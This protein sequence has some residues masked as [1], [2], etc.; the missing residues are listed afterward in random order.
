MALEELD[1]ERYQSKI[2]QCAAFLVDNQAKNG[3]WSYGAPIDLKAYP[4]VEVPKKDESVAKG[5]RDFVVSVGE[6]KRLAKQTV[7]QQRKA[8]GEKGANSI[9][10]YASLGLRHCHDANIKLPMECL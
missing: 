9:P 3:Q 8:S 1:A 2:A 4:Y 10:H 6:H 7:V 5:A